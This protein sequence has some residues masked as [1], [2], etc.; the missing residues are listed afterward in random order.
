MQIVLFKC[1]AILN[2]RPLIYIYPTDLT[3][4]LTPNHLLYGR[5]IQSLSIESSPLTNTLSQLTAYMN[6]VNT[7]INTFCDK[8]RHEYLANLK[9]THKY[10]CTNKNQPFMQ[11]NDVALVH[12]VNTPRSM[13]RMGVVNELINTFSN[14]HFPVF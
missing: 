6:K 8:W 13:W 14:K 2:N 3:L 4:C 5:V 7:A 11:V 1:E 9:N 12:S 10:Y